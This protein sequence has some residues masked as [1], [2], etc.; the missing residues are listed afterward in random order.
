MYFLLSLFVRSIDL[1]MEFMPSLGFQVDGEMDEQQDQEEPKWER[2]KLDGETPEEHAKQVL[3]IAKERF[4]KM[5]REGLE[6]D[7]FAKPKRKRKRRLGAEAFDA[8]SHV[9]GFTMEEQLMTQIACLTQGVLDC[10]ARASAEFTPDEDDDDDGYSRRSQATPDARRSNRAAELDS[11]T[12]LANAAA[13]LVD[14]VGRIQGKAHVRHEFT[15]RH[16]DRRHPKAPVEEPEPPEPT[17][18][19]RA[20]DITE[21]MFS[22]IKITSGG[23]DPPPPPTPA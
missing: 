10:T 11:Q 12:R 1:S 16:L 22:D 19:Q 20:D 4:R 15:Y 9:A 21:I 13:R 23:E 18:E 2:Q 7:K 3:E 5:I 8:I 14:T 17:P 6:G